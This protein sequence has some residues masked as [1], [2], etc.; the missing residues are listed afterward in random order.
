MPDANPRR[1]RGILKAAVAIGVFVAAVVIVAKVAIAAVGIL[2]FGGDG[3]G[4]ARADCA[5]FAFKRASWP[6]GDVLDHE[7]RARRRPIAAGLVQCDQLLGRSRRAVR[8]MLGPPERPAPRDSW[9]YNV[10][11]EQHTRTPLD[12]AYLTIRYDRGGV[13]SESVILEKDQ[14]FQD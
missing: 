7:V 12:D 11:E 5:T 4:P 14:E 13:V 8:S 10:G 6:R 2:A 3:A 1:R 9:Q